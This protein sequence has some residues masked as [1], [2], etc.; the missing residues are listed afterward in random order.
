M[1]LLLWLNEIATA[2]GKMKKTSARPLTLAYIALI[3][4]ASL[5]PFDNW[6]NQDILPWSFLLAPYTPYWTAFDVMSNFLGYAPLGFGL[7]LSYLRSGVGAATAAC[8]SIFWSVILSFLME[9]LQSYLP[10]R[11]PSA[12]DW[13]LNDAGAAFGAIVAIALEK[14][15]LIAKWAVLRNQWFLKDT[16]TVLPLLFLWP[17]ALLFPSVV[18][19]GLGQVGERVYS[20]LNE[21]VVSA[22]LQEWISIPLLVLKPLNAYTKMA[23]LF[24]GFLGPGLLGYSIIPNVNKRI[25]F[26]LILLAIALIFIGL[27]SALSFGPSNAWAWFDLP[28][29]AGL[30]LSLI[31]CVMLKDASIKSCL[32]LSLLV[33]LAN[34]FVL[35]QAPAGPYFAQTL[36]TWEQGKFIRFH[37]LAQWL[38]WVWPYAL[39]S[40]VLVRLLART[41]RKKH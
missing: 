11:V 5:Y 12:S 3:A 18:P 38:G 4:Y 6:R 41:S 10:T 31:F 14:K 13:A 34:L 17:L 32:F 25:W 9:S 7:A 15:G 40:D 36:Q 29:A 24:M 26:S 22:N 37:G 16:G 33:T 1:D 27:S 8:K 20:L 28:V 19:L 39:I 2:I 35:N 23:C 30:F 21:V